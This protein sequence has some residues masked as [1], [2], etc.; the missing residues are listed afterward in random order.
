MLCCCPCPE[1]EWEERSRTTDQCNTA[2]ARRPRRRSDDGDVP[3]AAGGCLF[4]FL[5]APLSFSLPSF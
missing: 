1:D 2:A 4:C 5:V 3:I